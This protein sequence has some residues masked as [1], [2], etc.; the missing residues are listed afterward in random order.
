MAKQ[1][2]TI[3]NSFKR[4]KQD[5]S[6]VGTAEFTEWCFFVANFIYKRTK[7]VDPERYISTNAYS[8]SSS[9]SSQSLPAT[10]GDMRPDGTGI[11]RQ[12]ADGNPTTERLELTGYGSRLKGYWLDSENV[13]FTGI[14]ASESYVMRFMPIITEYSNQDAYFTVDGTVSGKPILPDSE[15]ESIIKGLDE[16]Y[17]QWDNDWA[18]EGVAGQRL[19]NVLS[20][21]LSTL[22]RAP[23]VYSV[24]Q[25]HSAF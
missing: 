8:V 18:Y 1:L 11:F 7:N 5:I 3:R 6:D 25:A 13:N 16:K 15:L 4:L 14:N 20:D 10:F 12:D 9:P 17:S 24:P 21:L 23:N 2:S 19:A 22:R